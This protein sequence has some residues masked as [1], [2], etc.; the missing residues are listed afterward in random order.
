MALQQCAVNEINSNS[1]INLIQEHIESAIADNR[2]ITE[3]LNPHLH[4]LLHCQQN[5]T[6]PEAHRKRCHELNMEKQFYSENKSEVEFEHKHKP[7][8]ELDSESESDYYVNQQSLPSPGPVLGHTQLVDVRKRPRLEEFSRYSRPSALQMFG[9]EVRILDRTGESKTLR[10]EPCSSGSP[11]TTMTGLGPVS[12]SETASIVVRSSLHSGGTMLQKPVIE[13]LSV[14]RN[15]DH[16][17]LVTLAPNISPP[18]LAPSLGILQ[19]SESHSFSSRL[20]ESDKEATRV[21]VCAP[22]FGN[23]F[24]RPSSLPLKLGSF[25][26]KCYN[27]VTPITNT[28]TLVSP[29]TPRPKKSY[30]QLYLNGHAYT[31]L[32]LKCSTRLFYCTLNRPQPMYVTQQHGLSMYS[33]W[34]IC[35]EAPPELELARYDSRHRPAGYTLASGRHEDI[36]THSSQRPCAPNSPDSGLES[37][38]QERARRLRLFDSSFEINEDYTH[39]NGKS[40]GER[41]QRSRILMGVSPTIIA[42]RGRYICE[43]CGIHCKKP[44][45]LKKHIRTHTNLR[46]YRCTL[47]A[48]SFKTKG[49]LTKH[50]KSKAHRKKC[51]ESRILYTKETT[52]AQYQNSTDDSSTSEE[53]SEFEAEAESEESGGEE[54]E[55]ARGLL[56]LAR[57]VALQLPGLLSTDR[58]ATYPYGRV[59]LSHRSEEPAAPID[60]TTRQPEEPVMELAS[61]ASVAERASLVAE[62]PGRGAGSSTLRLLSGLDVVPRRVVVGGP[63][64]QVTTSSAIGVPN[65]ASISEDARSVCGICSKVFSKPSQLRLHINIHYFER[66]FRCESCGTSFRTKGHL[67]K[68]ERSTLH[69]NKVSMTST[70]GAATASNP[71]PFKC[72]DCKSAFRIHG[73]LAKHLRSKMHIMKLECLRKLPFGTYAEIERSSVNL[74]DIDTNDCDTSLTSLQ[75]IAQKL[76]EKDPSKLEQWEIRMLPVISG[77]DSSSDEDETNP[78]HSTS[79]Q[80]TETHLSQNCYMT[81]CTQS[82]DINLA[83][84]KLDEAR[85]NSIYK[86]H[87]CPTSVQNLKLE[88]LLLMDIN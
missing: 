82:S 53:E 11:N 88:W 1:K 73:H 8:S 61:L 60:L 17:G 18:S 56:S 31:Y 41:Q 85:K 70:F 4:E 35:K 32:G 50:M 16:L 45:M 80:C 26:P 12:G 28:L 40:D 39:I 62:L 14:P 36:L 79:Q 38:S 87:L 44:S 42:G 21:T 76:F 6:I 2:T 43:E 69:H 48:F 46:P 54:R 34:K 51:I 13:K 27:G 3:A 83:E 74:N 7:K 49:N 65:F 86:C 5:S 20:P 71:R 29:E 81:K 72:T 33:N 24:L 22:P 58:P 9:G 64:F 15:S 30:G 23:K 25:T 78:V 10:I 84:I 66:P 37:D 59:A 75:I 57:P 68:H 77:G 55:A 47:C 52:G 63:A 19:T 67:T